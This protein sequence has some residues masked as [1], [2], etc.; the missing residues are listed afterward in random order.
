MAARTRIWTGQ[1]RHYIIKS[2]RRP[3]RRIFLSKKLRRKTI[4]R[5]AECQSSVDGLWAIRTMDHV[6]C[7]HERL[8]ILVN[9]NGGP[10]LTAMVAGQSAI[11]TT[12]SDGKT[13]PPPDTVESTHEPFHVGSTA[14]RVIP[15][16]R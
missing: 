4:R 3:G 14:D 6:A 2:L 8:L 12:P 1:S 15:S 9:A 5:N 10:A 16:Q 11:A 7:T 13:P